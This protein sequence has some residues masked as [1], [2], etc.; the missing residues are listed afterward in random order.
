MKEQVKRRSKRRKNRAAEAGIAAVLSAVVVI[1]GIYA[2]A[3]SESG[4]RRGKVPSLVMEYAQLEIDLSGLNSR[5]GILVRLSDGQV[6]ARQRQD[7]KIFPAS[8]TK[9]MTCII[10]LETI[11]DLEAEISMPEDIFPPLYADNASMAGFL[12]GEHVKIMDLLYGIILPSGGECSAAAAEYAAGSQEAFVKLMNEKAQELGMDNTHFENVTGLHDENH[13]T[14]VSDLAVL[15]EYALRNDTFEQI[16]SSKEHFVSPTDGHPEGLMLKSSMFVLE[17]DWTVGRG[18]IRG[19]KTGYTDQS[20]L[21]LA[22][23]AMLGN[24]KYIAVTAGAEGNHSTE[25]Y[26][27]LDAFYLYD[28]VENLWQVTK[29]E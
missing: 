8:L 15:L 17:Q 20:G 23:E 22:T 25:P 4:R 12:P 11:D 16:F 5:A 27:V 14:T 29:D 21:C 19:G 3:G 18:E 7:E 13:Y 28:Q 2:F 1:G 24:E 10:A 26:H 9:I 6:I